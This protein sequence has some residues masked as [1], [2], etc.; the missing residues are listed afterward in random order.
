MAEE[1]S[2]VSRA[3]NFTRIASRGILV[4]CVC[5]SLAAFAGEEATNEVTPITEPVSD[6]AVGTS[7]I[8]RSDN[9]ESKLSAEFAEFLGGEDRAED[10]VEGLRT[11]NEFKLDET[12]DSQNDMTSSATAP[13]AGLP[14]M[15]GEA[16]GSSTIDPPTG[17][18]GYGNVRITLRLAEAQLNKLG[19]SQPTNDELSAMLV[20]G[21]IDGVPV[22][23]ILNERAAGA[24]WGE[25]AKKYDFKVGQLMGKAPATRPDAAPVDEARHQG[26]TETAASSNGYIPS[27]KTK[28]TYGSQ[29]AGKHEQR[30]KT[31]GAKSNGYIPSGSPSHTT[32]ANHGIGGS[33]SQNQNNAKKNGYIPSGKA[34]GS[35]AG[36]VSAQGA[37]TASQAKVGHGHSKGHMNGYVPSG[38]SRHGLGIVSATNASA[39]AAVSSAGGHG[40]AKG[41]VKGHGKSK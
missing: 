33:G 22:E 19:I 38:G 39:S 8:G 18:M 35:G 3:Q 1:G 36:I 31:R 41:S 15:G 14:P 7:L 27:G 34:V 10:V 16:A 26:T 6:S 4:S 9:V 24:G 17:K 5:F 12:T 37:A 29:P 20:G 21:E 2:I 32:A 28:F 25:I 40:H 30:M 11:G 13:D 23:G